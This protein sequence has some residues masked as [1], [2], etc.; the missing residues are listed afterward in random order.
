MADYAAQQRRFAALTKDEVE[1]AARKYFA[2]EKLIV[3]TAGDFTPKPNPNP[4]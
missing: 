1:A 2:P 4:Q 3:V